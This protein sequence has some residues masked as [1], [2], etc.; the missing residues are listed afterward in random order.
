MPLGK[1]T[2]YLFNSVSLI[3]DEIFTDRREDI[4]DARTYFS[5][6]SAVFDIFGD[7]VQVSGMKCLLF[8]SDHETN[9]TFQN[10]SCL[11][12]RVGVQRDFGL[13]VEINE[14]QHEVITPEGASVHTGC[15][16]AGFFFLRVVEVGH[17]N[18]FFL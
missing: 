12:V 11:F 9:F 2:S 3:F 10:S 6:G 14:H 4:H 8:T 18:S 1:I 16:V 5:C 7:E 15:K 17:G 13:G